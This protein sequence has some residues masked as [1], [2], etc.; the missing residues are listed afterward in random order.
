MNTIDQQEIA[1]D[2]GFAED[3]MQSVTFHLERAV[4]AVMKHEHEWSDA[5]VDDA[6]IGRLEDNCFTALRTVED[7]VET[8][9][10]A[11]RRVERALEDAEVDA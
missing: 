4:E 3:M 2:F 8:M 7:L 9:R 11:T 5:G 1:E 6:T 10:R